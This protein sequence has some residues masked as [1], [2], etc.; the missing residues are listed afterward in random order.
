MNPRGLRLPACG[1]ALCIALAGCGGSFEPDEAAVPADPGQS[2]SGQAAMPVQAAATMATVVA[3]SAAPQAVTNRPTGSA[4][5]DL[6]VRMVRLEAEV[7]ALRR[8][9]GAVPATAAAP[10]QAATSESA[11][12]PD[13]T[14]ARFRSEAADPTW[15]RTA[16][17]QVRQAISQADPAL[18]QRLQTVDCRTRQ[19]RL[20]FA[21]GDDAVSVEAALPRV[22]TELDSAFA[23]ARTQP[24]DAGPGHRGTVLFLSR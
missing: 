22:I 16:A 10:A 9:Q 14:E 21:T 13:A 11:D 18:V 5:D 12:T 23:F 7:A 8:A 4:T 3:P 1:A 15:S 6:L 2:G 19:C 20:E 17:L 24:M